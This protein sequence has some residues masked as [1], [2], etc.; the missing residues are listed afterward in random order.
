LSQ[1]S[2]SRAI[3]GM[4][5]AAEGRGKFDGLEAELS[6]EREHR[7]GQKRQGFWVPHSVLATRV[8]NI[9]ETATLGGDL[10]PG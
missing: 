10:F 9:V 5:D 3:D 8:D 6:R 2:I 1:H 7:S 4:R